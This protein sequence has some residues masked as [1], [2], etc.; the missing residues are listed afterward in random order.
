MHAVGHYYT[1]E[2]ERV[3]FFMDYEGGV[4]CFSYQGET[5]KVS[6]Y[7]TGESCLVLMLMGDSFWFAQY[8]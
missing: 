8:N 4:Y 1:D 6:R 7:L 5:R 3:L 2:Y